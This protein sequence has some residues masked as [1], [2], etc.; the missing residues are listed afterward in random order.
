MRGTGVFA[1]PSGLLL[2]PPRR[3]G[4]AA[5]IEYDY[6]GEPFRAVDADGKWYALTLLYRRRVA[7]DGA[8]FE[9]GFPNDCIGFRTDVGQDAVADG[10]HRYL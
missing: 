4:F 8:T 9:T 2:P 5:P 1:A 3:R 6:E 10:P 7:K